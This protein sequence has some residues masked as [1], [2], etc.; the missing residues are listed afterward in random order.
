MRAGPELYIRRIVNRCTSHD[1]CFG[2]MVAEREG[3]EP[4]EPLQ[5]HA[6]S[7]RA[8]SS[9]LSSFPA[10]VNVTKWAY[11]H[12]HPPDGQ[13]GRRDS[14]IWIILRPYLD[15]NPKRVVEN[16]PFAPASDKISVLTPL[17]TGHMMFWDSFTQPFGP[18]PTESDTHRRTRP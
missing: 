8:Q 2:R 4:S 14:L 17:G 1:E 6:I 7:S 18:Q 13:T 11:T 15:N 3:F 10:R 12:Q 9:T 5:A 16:R